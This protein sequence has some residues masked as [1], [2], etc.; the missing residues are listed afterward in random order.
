MRGGSAKQVSIATNRLAEVLQET[1][2]LLMDAELI[3]DG[4]DSPPEP[5]PSLLQQCVD[6]VESGA[7]P[8]T[9]PIRTVHHFACTG[10]TVFSKCIASMPN[11]QLLSEV[12]PLSTLSEK[13]GKP[14]FAPTDMVKLIRQGTSPMPRDTVI[15]LFQA[16]LEV[17]YDTTRS[18]GMYLVIR[19]HTHSH[20]CTGSELAL[21]PTLRELVEAV[22]PTRS[23]VTV[24][25][26]VDTFLSLQSH[27]WVNF[28]PATFDEYCKRYLSF[29]DCYKGIPV[30]R[31]EDFAREPTSEVRRACEYLEIPYFDGFL[32]VFGVF[33]LTGDSGRKPAGG[34]SA[35][36]PREGH[37][38]L[39][40]EA[41]RSAS[42]R[43]LA[44]RLRYDR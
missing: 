33:H 17:I 7:R 28:E 14:I 6:L 32:R 39:Q 13:R 1:V 25:H 9:E 42:Y 20:F 5:E 4:I 43:E 19:D 27:N 40:A 36:P 30:L 18:Q 21:R 2:D 31:Y 23:L 16:E 24:R 41:A 37:E 22:A 29:L 38:A 12:D 35:P 44:G 15:K 10:G 26:P 8:R 11:V 34:I 3:H